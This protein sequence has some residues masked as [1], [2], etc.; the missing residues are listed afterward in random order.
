MS[1]YKVIIKA[2]VNGFRPKTHEFN[3]VAR[4]RRDASYQAVERLNQELFGLSPRI[5]RISVAQA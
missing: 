4:N 1:S 3:L 5:Q 2:A